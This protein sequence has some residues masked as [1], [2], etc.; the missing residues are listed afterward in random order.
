MQRVRPFMNSSAVSVTA[1]VGDEVELLGEDRLLEVAA[2]EARERARPPTRGRRWSPRSLMRRNHGWEAVRALRGTASFASVTSTFSW[3]VRKFFVR[4]ISC[5]AS[6]V[7]GVEG[8]R[9]L[10]ASLTPTGRAARPPSG[11]LGERMGSS[12]CTETDCRRT[13]PSRKAHERRAPD[14]RHGARRGLAGTTRARR[15]RASSSAPKLDR[16]LTDRCRRRTRMQRGRP[17]I[18][19]AQAVARPSNEIVAVRRR[20]PS[21]SRRT[22]TAPSASTVHART[23][24]SSTASASGDASPGRVSAPATAAWRALPSF[25]GRN[26][27]K[28]TQ[29]R[30]T[31][32]VVTATIVPMPPIVIARRATRSAIADPP[33]RH[34]LRARGR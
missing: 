34:A 33:R 31:Q 22:S 8:R 19:N 18:P 26:S 14:R 23:R 28:T 15:R 29:T 9:E 20:S 6:D 2:V 4:T 3:S 27:G 5:I 32:I 17:P 1:G 25:P 10:A 7:V 30:N 11:R 16:G 24:Y 12:T 13:W 21:S